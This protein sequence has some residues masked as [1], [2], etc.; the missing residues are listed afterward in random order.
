ML[1]QKKII[2][3][4][5]GGSLL[6]YDK[7]CKL[8]HG[9]TFL[10]CTLL[11]GRGYCLGTFDSTNNEKISY[12]ISYSISITLIISILYSLYLSLIIRGLLAL[13]VI[14]VFYLVILGPL[15]FMQID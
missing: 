12:G 8:M 15:T 2:K 13:T 9:Y 6:A 5:K 14:L 3:L 10:F 4:D 1:L 7:V 11:G